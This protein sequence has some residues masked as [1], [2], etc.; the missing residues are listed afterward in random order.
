MKPNSL[1]TLFA[2]SPAPPQRGPSSYVVSILAHAAGCVWLLFGLSHTPRIESTP[3]LRRFTVRVLEAPAVTPRAQPPSAPVA[4]AARSGSHEAAKEVAA[5]DAPAPMPAA[6]SQMKRP[7]HQLQTLIQPDAPPDVILQRKTPVPTVFMWTPVTAP[8]KPVIQAPLQRP[9]LSQLRPSI[10]PPNREIKMADIRLSSSNAATAMKSLA[11]STTSP[12]VVR[13]P[14]IAQQM[15]ETAAKPGPEPTPVRIMSIS[16]FQQEGPVAIPLASATARPSAANSTSAGRAAN[17]TDAS[18]GNTESKQAGV[19][20]GQATGASSNSVAAANKGAA[21]SGVNSQVAANSNK[22]VA[23]SS[24]NPQVATNSNKGVGGSG[25]N[26]QAGA[27]YAPVQATGMDTGV[28]NLGPVTHINL[29]K[30]GQFGVVVVGSSLAEQYPE[31][32]NVWGGR[33]VY[34]VYLHVGGGKNWI[35]QY[36]VPNAS[37]GAGNI[38][39]DAPWPYDIVRPRFDPEDFSSDALLVHGF[40]NSAGRFERLALVFPTEFAKVKFLLN[41]LQQWEFRPARQNGQAAAVEVLLIIPEQT[42]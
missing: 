1:I 37:G 22:G 23:G 24:A 11:A 41:A 6:A 5:N 42:E 17:A 3:S 4:A 8:I 36:S 2:P 35:L 38:R 27:S 31:I 14:E 34:S 33:L 32:V 40:V 12:I 9:V 7:V 15:P 13:T 26:P 19:G 16:E 25:T 29:P 20:S 30:D 21:G 39:P 18:H 10:E 28:I